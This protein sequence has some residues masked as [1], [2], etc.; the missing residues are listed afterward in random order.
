MTSVLSKQPAANSNLLSSRQP[1]PRDASPRDVS[2]LLLPYIPPSSF[3]NSPWTMDHYR[4]QPPP[5]TLKHTKSKGLIG[6]IGT[7]LRPSTADTPTSPPPP[8]PT[9]A[10][11]Q[12]PHSSH[13]NEGPTVKRKPTRTRMLH[14]PPLDNAFTPE[15][16][17]AALRARG[18]I[19]QKS[20]SKLEEEENRRI[21]VAKSSGGGGGSGG[22]DGEDGASAARLMAEQWRARNSLSGSRPGMGAGEADQGKASGFAP[23]YLEKRFRNTHIVLLPLLTFSSRTVLP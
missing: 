20:L 5:P 3:V 18:L 6:R 23:N 11:H 7:K 1:Y 12:D 4:Q 13:H 17:E 15:A 10:S 21:G 8:P 19:P 9:H 22:G 16:R 14:A 2:S